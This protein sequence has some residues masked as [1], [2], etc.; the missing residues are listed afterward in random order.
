MIILLFGFLMKN[1]DLKAE[2]E[3][4][5]V[6]VEYRRYGKFVDNVFMIEVSMC[7]IVFEF[8]VRDV[9]VV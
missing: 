4:M 7:S 2:V 8:F 1:E 5:V 6:G 3:E 9:E